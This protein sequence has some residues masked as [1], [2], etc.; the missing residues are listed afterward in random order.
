M[1]S[2]SPAPQDLVVENIIQ[3][4]GNHL[5]AEWTRKKIP[6]GLY[7]A[8]ARAELDE[9]ESANV[10]FR[11]ASFRVWLAY[12]LASCGKH[13]FSGRTAQLRTLDTFNK[14]PSEKKQSAAEILAA[15]VPHPTVKDAINKI[16]TRWKTLHR[17]PICIA[18]D[19]VLSELIMYSRLKTS[20]NIPASFDECCSHKLNRHGPWQHD[21]RLSSTAT[22]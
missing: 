11:R 15:I 10:I 3:V 20:R 6:N 14:L 1:Q 13:H 21:Q 22:V 19:F 12:W 5:K 18:I 2:R 16:L 9:E 8:Y 7:E 17:K 4:V